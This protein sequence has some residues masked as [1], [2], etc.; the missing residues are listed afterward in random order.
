MEAS[1][2]ITTAIDSE[3]TAINKNAKCDILETTK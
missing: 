2:L 1:R 3:R